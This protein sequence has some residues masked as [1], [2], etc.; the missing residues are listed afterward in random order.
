M[1]IDAS[2]TCNQGLV[3]ANSQPVGYQVTE[4]GNPSRPG[5]KLLPAEQKDQ[6]DIR[7]QVE[8][9]EFHPSVLGLW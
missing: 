3:S 6:I 4:M 5:I 1:V 8:K 2:I 7:A 9:A